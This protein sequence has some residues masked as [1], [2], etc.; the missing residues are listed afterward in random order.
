MSSDVTL[1]LK[2]VSAKLN[3]SKS[4]KAGFLRQLEGDVSTYA[5]QRESVTTDEL[6]AEFGSP[7]A[8]AD[9]FLDR[10][11]C[12]E[13]LKQSK[14]K[15]MISKAAG[16]ASVILLAAAIVVF[17]VVIYELSGVIVHSV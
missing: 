11:V 9:S 8:I 1:Y 7:E 16:V 3:C 12:D 6:C 2:S 10:T 15:S 14:K 5:A 13:R 17:A 4:L